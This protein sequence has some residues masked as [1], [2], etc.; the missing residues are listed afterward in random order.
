MEEKERCQNQAIYQYAWA[1]KIMRGCEQHAN[2][3]NTLA[4]FMGTPF[5][6]ETI[7][8]TTCDHPNDLEDEKN[9]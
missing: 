6:V 7:L 4:H 8:P 2:S 5:Q 3:M 9:Q 1:G